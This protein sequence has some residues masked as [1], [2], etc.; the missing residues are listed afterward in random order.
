MNRRAALRSSDSAGSRL[1]THPQGHFPDRAELLRSGQPPLLKRNHPF[2]VATSTRPGQ[3]FRRECI[4][5]MACWSKVRKQIDGCKPISGAI[6]RAISQAGTKV[7]VMAPRPFSSLRNRNVTYGSRHPGRAA[8]VADCI[9]IRPP[10]PREY[11]T[12]TTLQSS[13]MRCGGR[14]AGDGGDAQPPSLLLVINPE[15]FAMRKVSFW[16]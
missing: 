9:R 13:K 12:P 4:H 10:F 2:A 7:A 14:A 5:F 3:P 16:T 15:I 6:V 11:A 1:W 8:F